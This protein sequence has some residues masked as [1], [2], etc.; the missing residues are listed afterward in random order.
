MFSERRIGILLD[1]TFFDTA[2]F[3]VEAWTETAD[4][5]GV[6]RIPT[7]GLEVSGMNE[8]QA[9]IVFARYYSQFP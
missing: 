7:L 4:F 1:S 2:K 8:A 5:F 3:Y 9:L 6:E